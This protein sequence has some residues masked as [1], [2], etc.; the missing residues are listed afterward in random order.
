[1]AT[2]QWLVRIQSGES[3]V[4]YGFDDGSD[5]NTWRLDN[6]PPDTQSRTWISGDGGR[7]WCRYGSFLS[8]F[9]HCGGNAD[10]AFSQCN[11]DSLEKVPPGRGDPVRPLYK[12]GTLPFDYVR[13]RPT[14]EDGLARAVVAI[15]VGSGLTFGPDQALFLNRLWKGLLKKD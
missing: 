12:P 6:E 4:T 15:L 14:D 5:A 8:D 9:E 7:G 10:A 13:K 11:K 2:F 1:M 3:V